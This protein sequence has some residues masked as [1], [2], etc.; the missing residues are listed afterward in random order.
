MIGTRITSTVQQLE[1]KDKFIAMLY[2]DMRKVQRKVMLSNM[3]V[4]AD[5]EFMR[6]TAAHTMTLCFCR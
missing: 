3:G 1:K 4:C 6:G 5:F 2:V